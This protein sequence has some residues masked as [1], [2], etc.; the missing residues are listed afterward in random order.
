ML[1]PTLCANT[2]DPL[3]CL[4]FALGPPVSSGLGGGL[5]LRRVCGS[6]GRGGQH[7]KSMVTAF[8]VRLR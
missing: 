6:R 7:C 2:W 1:M 4:S 5:W 8:I 3:L